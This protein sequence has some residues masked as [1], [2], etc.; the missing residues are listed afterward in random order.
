MG[1]DKSR[2]LNAVTT[3][4]T[5]ALGGQT[6]L[7]VA[8]NTLAPYAANV[9]GEKFG[10]GEDKNKAAQLASHAI[11]GAT[12]AYLNGGNPAAGGSAAVASEAAADYFANQYNDGKTAINPETGKFDANLLPENVKSGIRDLTA[13]IGAVVGGTVGDS[14]SNAQ[15]AGVIGQNAVENNFLSVKEAARKNA[16]IYKSKHEELSSNEK[17]ELAEINRKDKARDE[18]IKN[19]CQLGN[20]SSSACQSALQAAWSTQADYNADIANNLKNRDVYSQDAKHLDQLLKGL[21]QDQVL[22]LQAIE[23]IAKTSGRPVEEVAKEYDRAMALHGVVSTLA[24]FYGGKAISVEK[25]KNGGGSF[26]A[27]TEAEKQRALDNIANSK[28]GR[29]SSNFDTHVINEKVAATIP[30]NMQQFLMEHNTQIGSRNSQGSIGGS[31]NADSFNQALERSKSAIIG[32]PVIDPKYPG[33]K[34]YNYQ[35]P[36]VDRA[37]KPTGNYKDKQQ[38][39]VYDPKVI[40]DQKMVSMQMQA[41]KKGAELLLS[42]PKDKRE[43]NVNIEGDIFNVTR[44]RNTGKISNAFPIIPNAPSPVIPPKY[45]SKNIK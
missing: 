43:V 9:I 24:G 18:F 20:V 31:H 5:G 35:A 38:K 42:M 10:H 19:V 16:L 28:I 7:Q 44:D 17:K 29:E 32:D 22:G 45:K 21:S 11:L 12:L 37:G 34:T 25:V 8:A 3:A 1:G 6:D 27:L 4:I 40:S 36:A 33:L 26:N 41:V 15:L 39:T 14:A 13:A 23:R 2:A 30:P